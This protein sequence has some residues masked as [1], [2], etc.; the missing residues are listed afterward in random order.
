LDRL[1]FL[2]NST[3]CA[4]QESFQEINLP[5]DTFL[6]SADYKAGGNIGILEEMGRVVYVFR[7]LKRGNVGILQEMGVFSIDLRGGWGGWGVV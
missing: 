3:D 7:N 1:P 2:R 4:G 5:F 6:M